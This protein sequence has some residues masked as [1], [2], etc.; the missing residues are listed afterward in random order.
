MPN[1][2]EVKYTKTHEWVHVEGEIAVIGVSEH[3]QSEMGDIVFVELPKLGQNLEKEK[4]CAVIESV[5][6]AF[7][8]YSPLS[9]E[10]TEVNENLNSD[11]ALINSSPLENGWIFKVK[12]SNP[13]E[14]N[15]LM[16][17]EKY[18][19]FVKQNA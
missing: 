1:A 11:P 14:L 13:D 9:G 10:V 18:R 15:E 17:L 3:A 4:P 6:S 7:D 12:I 16:N 5:K 8:V 2:E 19:E